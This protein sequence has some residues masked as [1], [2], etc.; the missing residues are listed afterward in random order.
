MLVF[1]LRML[2]KIIQRLEILRIR[3]GKGEIRTLDT[4]SGMPL[5]ESGAFNHSATFPGGILFSST[6]K[7]GPKQAERSLGGLAVIESNRQLDI[8]TKIR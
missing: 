5:F 7:K 1:L 4:V 3:C 6:L 8:L 2:K